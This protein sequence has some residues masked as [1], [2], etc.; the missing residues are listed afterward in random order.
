M[1]AIIQENRIQ[2]DLLDHQILL[3]SVVPY[4]IILFIKTVILI[5]K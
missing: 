2:R 3:L 1:L 4:Q 5:V